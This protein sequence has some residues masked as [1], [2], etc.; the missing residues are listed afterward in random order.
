L[1]QINLTPTPYSIFNEFDRFGELLGLTRLQGEDN[2]AYKRRLLDVLVHKADSTYIG[3]IYGI[4]RELGLK[5]LDVMRI[6][7]I[8]DSNGDPIV[9]QPAIVFRDTKCY[10]YSNYIDKTLS[11]TID[12]FSVDSTAFTL[13][14]LADR[15][16]E[17]G[18]FTATLEAD[19]DPDTRAM[20]IFNQRSIIDVPSEDISEAGP[21]VVLSNQNLIQGTVAVRSANLV[22][23]VASETAITQDGDYFVNLKNGIIISSV[24]PAPGA[25]IRYQYRQDNFLVQASPVII[26]NLQ[27]EDFKTKMFEQVLDG[28]GEAVNGLPTSLGADLIN[29]LL[30]VYPSL[31]GL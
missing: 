7:P 23:R 19:G 17:S 22:R 4:T 6:I 10:L 13:S 27:S 20:T 26:H 12:R 9:T 3:L 11:D 14:E 8:L 16:N 5:I 18:F 25:F 29:G 24:A 21:K 28:T 30:S 1:A 2:A 15:I 31:W